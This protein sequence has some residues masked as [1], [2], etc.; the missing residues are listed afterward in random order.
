M[1]KVLLTT[2]AIMLWSGLASAAGGNMV[3]I[4]A[5]DFRNMMKEIDTL[6]KRVD[7][8]EK[9]SKIPSAPVAPTPVSV[10]APA[11]VAAPASAD[12]MRMSDDIN[13]IYDT[14][15][16]VET[17]TLKDR[18]NF[19]GEYRLR[20][21]QYQ[22][23]DLVFIHRVAPLVDG[24]LSP[25]HRTPY[26][27]APQS[28]SDGNNWVNRARINMEANISRS[29]KFH[30]RLAVYNAWGDYDQ[31]TLKN[32]YNNGNAAHRTGDTSLKLDRFYIDWIP[33]GSPIPLAITVGRHPSS[34]GPPSEFKEN[35]K[36]QSTYP[37]MMV[38]G[39]VDGLVVTLGLQRYIKMENS[40]L[41]FGY[42][43]V[44]HS[45]ADNTNYR[46]LDDDVSDSSLAALFFESKIP[47]VPRS[48]MVFGAMQVRDMPS[49]MDGQYEVVMNDTEEPPKNYY[50][51]PVNLG[52]ESFFAV[53]FQV[54]DIGRSGLDLFGSFSMNQPDPNATA[55]NSEGKYRSFKGTMQGLVSGTDANDDWQN[56]EDGHGFLVGLRYTVPIEAMNS[57]KIGFEYNKGSQFYCTMAGGSSELYNKLAT[58]GSAYDV[59]Y[60][61]P[62]DRFLF[63]R[64]G[65]TMI[66]YDYSGSG[67]PGGLP[68]AYTVKPSLTNYYFLM[69]VRF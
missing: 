33:K 30:G 11:P 13:N 49:N 36:R 61:Q 24:N 53:H 22:Y 4:S 19:G 10:V 68:V 56:A 50:E 5:G 6:Q 57:P 34:E 25:T 27:T 46:F 18:I 41:R 52:D 59:Y 51:R 8:I 45:D 43:K 17:K 20:Y 23:D 63:F 69:D 32:F 31:P 40:G 16:Q 12:L 37:A 55:T 15:D 3:R 39:E 54:S 66:E 29:L 38:D 64:T 2:G 48:L 21:D 44:Y 28:G 1:K 60:I 42:G 7:H 62:V 14:L 35:R 9:K 47:W 67:E 26:D 65:A 58:R